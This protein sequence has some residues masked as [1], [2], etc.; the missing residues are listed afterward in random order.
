MNTTRRVCPPEANG[1]AARALQLIHRDFA[2]RSLSLAT[3]S[4]AL[5]VSERHLARSVRSC[6]G[7]TFRQYLRAARIRH[8]AKLLAETDHSVKA[9]ASIVGYP[10]LSHF[11]RYF[12]EATGMTPVEYRRDFARLASLAEAAAV[13]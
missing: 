9:V 8:A 7:Q 3:L 5:H 2:E 11:S 12:K 1:H 6:T 13:N 4:H 10:D